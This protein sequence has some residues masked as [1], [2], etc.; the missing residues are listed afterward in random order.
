MARRLSRNGLIITSILGGAISFV[1]IFIILFVTSNFD[2]GEAWNAIKNANIWW[3]LVA[4]AINLLSFVL[5]TLQHIII[6][7]AMGKMTSFWRM[8]RIYFLGLFFEYTSPSTSGGQPMQVWF[9]T[10][11]DYTVAEATVLVTMKGLISVIIRIVYVVIIFAM[12]PFG[13][14]L[15][16]QTAQYSVFL[17]TVVGFLL[18]VAG[19]LIILAK[20]TWFSFVFKF[21]A[22]FRLMRKWM[23]VKT[24]TAFYKK[25]KVV[26]TEVRVSAKM[27]LK[28]SKPLVALAVINSTVTWTLLKLMPYFVLLA[29]GVKANVLAVIA[30][31]VIAQLSTAWVPT[32]GAV[33]G[34]ETGYTV[35]FMGIPG[36]AT[37]VGPF[38]LIYRVLDYH[39][40]ILIS[41]PFA[42]SML[43]EKLGKRFTNSQVEEIEHDMEEEMEH[44]QEE[45]AKS[46][47]KEI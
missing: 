29:L 38:L 2:L 36:I 45:I 37:S 26:L 6:A 25:G 10:D 20:P 4:G 21:L 28:R 14:N 39:M 19:G 34:A 7:R 13:F 12:V 8:M 23:G 41:G 47:S 11:E 42:I 16:L 44:S 18:L 3:I 5:E 24:P 46:T 35:F 22:R 27:L 40:D 15:N 1:V 30:M 32:P 33:G 31:G 43:T 17:A 9:L